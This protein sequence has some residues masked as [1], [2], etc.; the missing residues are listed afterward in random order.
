MLRELTASEYQ[1]AYALIKGDSARNY[2][3]RLG[4]ESQKPM[5]EKIMGEWD[6][7]GILKAALFKRMSGN[8]QFYGREDFDAEGFGS[9]IEQM[10]FKVLISPRS[11]CDRL[12]ETSTLALQKEGA[13]IARLDV[14]QSMPRTQEAMKIEPL[15]VAD[16]DEVIALYQEVF[17]SFSSKAVMHK[18]L[19]SGR[20]RGVCIRQNG[21]LVSVVQSEFE[22]ETS[23][24]IVGVATTKDMQGKGFAAECLKHLC[25]ELQQEGKTLYLQY[26]NPAAGRIYRRLGFQPIDR[27]GHYIK[28]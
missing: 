7:Q 5:F 15:T 12:T 20:G 9:C 10:D 6:E 23:A 24:L 27:I 14:A 8:L 3:I 21:R 19:D 13:F 1:E 26:D 16:L 28:R 4:L 17:E 2:F 25:H 22:E 11:Y 18:R